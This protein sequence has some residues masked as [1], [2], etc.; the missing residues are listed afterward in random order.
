M[1]V[2]SKTCE[3]GIRSVF[4]IAHRTEGGNKVSI[5]EIATGI[6]SPEH[7][8][9]KIL[10]DLSRKGIVKSTKGPNG[11]FYMDEASLQRPLLDVV[12]ATDGNGLFSGCG[13]G[14]VSCS[15]SKPCPLHNEFKV[16]RH[17]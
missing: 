8:L 17:N 2:F 12:E 16:I 15:E 1:G 6:N 3:Y 11:G 4:F 13:L 10:Q 9:A 14:L 7:F 5:K